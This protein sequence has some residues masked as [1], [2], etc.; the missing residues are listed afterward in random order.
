MAPHLSRPVKFC[1]LHASAML[2]SPSGQQAFVE[3]FQ[4]EAE[5]HDGRIMHPTRRSVLMSDVFSTFCDRLAKAALVGTS[6]VY[7]ALGS[8]SDGVRPAEEH[9]SKVRATVVSRVIIQSSK[10]C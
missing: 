10:L 6:T 9:S 7:V 5:M 8:C 4:L 1:Y 2:A 3:P